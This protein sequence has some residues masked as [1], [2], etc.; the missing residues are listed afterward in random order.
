MADI[1]RHELHTLVDH[2]PES[3]GPAARKSRRAG[4]EPG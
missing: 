1:D 4:A 2:S 3:E